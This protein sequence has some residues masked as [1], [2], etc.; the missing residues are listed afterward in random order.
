[1]YFFRTHSYSHEVFKK[2]M[3]NNS[4]EKNGVRK[5]T[6]TRNYLENISLPWKKILEELK[7]QRFTKIVF[8]TKI[9]EKTHLIM[10][11]EKSKMWWTLK[12]Y[13]RWNNEY[14]T[15]T[16]VIISSSPSHV[17]SILSKSCS[18]S[19]SNSASMSPPEWSLRLSW[20]ALQSRRPDQ[21]EIRLGF[22]V[23]VSGHL[24][25]DFELNISAG[26]FTV[27]PFPFFTVQL[28]WS[29]WKLAWAEKIPK[30]S[31]SALDFI[32]WTISLVSHTG[33]CYTKFTVFHSKFKICFSKL[34]NSCSCTDT[35]ISSPNLA[36]PNI[37]TK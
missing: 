1:M 7:F 36:K 5:L 29:K 37:W 16:L 27:Q 18:W 35:T 25:F 4:G 30:H 17:P 9:S 26:G 3:G 34:V 31:L 10:S 23:L 21:Q 8:N 19:L 2:E 28:L 20:S 11:K 32:Q 24:H 13:H 12:Y 6:D 33:K 15:R 14:Q 22:R